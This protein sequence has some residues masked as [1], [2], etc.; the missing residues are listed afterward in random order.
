VDLELKE[1]GATPKGTINSP[2]IPALQ[3]LSVSLPSS[4]N[5]TSSARPGQIHSST[6]EDLLEPN[7]VAILDERP[8]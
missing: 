1:V 5:I 4:F 3:F 8:R 2:Y 7:Q 6:W